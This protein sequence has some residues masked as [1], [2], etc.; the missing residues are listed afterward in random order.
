MEV[1]IDVIG[2][3]HPIADAKKELRKPPPLP[4]KRIASSSCVLKLPPSSIHLLH[5]SDANDDG[6]RWMIIGNSLHTATSSAQ[7]VFGLV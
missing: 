1:N 3:I 7:F 6:V 2:I 5:E 4:F